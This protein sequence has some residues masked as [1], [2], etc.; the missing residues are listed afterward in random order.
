[1]TPIKIKCTISSW[2]KIMR[3]RLTIHPKAVARQLL[4]RLEDHKKL[5][6]TEAAMISDAL[7][8]SG[9]EDANSRLSASF[10]R[11]VLRAVV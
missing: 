8:N 7:R 4:N 9:V 2:Y 10:A 1:M 3:N 5:S 11:L 6:A